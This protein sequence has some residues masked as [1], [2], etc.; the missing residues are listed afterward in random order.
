MGALGYRPR[1]LRFAPVARLV[2][3]RY[4][5]AV[6]WPRKPRSVCAGSRASVEPWSPEEAPL[7]FFGYELGLRKA[8][9]AL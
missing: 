5:S 7:S 4:S 3:R 1:F 2:S 9:E 8:P 6:V